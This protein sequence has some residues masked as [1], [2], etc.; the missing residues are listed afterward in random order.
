MPK[1]ILR[2]RLTVNAW[3]WHQAQPYEKT[4]QNTLALVDGHLNHVKAYIAICK[5][6]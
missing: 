2:F 4:V 1:N 3:I 5:G 6:K